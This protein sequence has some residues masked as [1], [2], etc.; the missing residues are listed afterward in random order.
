MQFCGEFAG[1]TG[2]LWHSHIALLSDSEKG[3][4]G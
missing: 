4:V 2:Y 1:A 3:S